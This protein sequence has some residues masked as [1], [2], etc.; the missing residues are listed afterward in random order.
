VLPVVLTVDEVRQTFSFMEGTSLLMTQLLYGA[1]LRIMELFRLPA[2]IREALRYHLNEVK[3]LHE[4]D[5]AADLERFICPTIQ[6]DLLLMK[7]RGGQTI[8]SFFGFKPD[9]I[10]SAIK[11]R[12]GNEKKNIYKKLKRSL[13]RPSFFVMGAYEEGFCVSRG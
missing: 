11:R 12:S 9:V 7:K 2:G 6:L 13:I 4:R 5:L 10:P 3:A 8:H 1:G